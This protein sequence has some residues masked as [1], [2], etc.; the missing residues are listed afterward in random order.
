MPPS[1]RLLAK[2]ISRPSG[3]QSGS[4]ST[5]WKVTWPFGFSEP[6]PNREQARKKH[7]ER[8]S[9]VG[10][11]TGRED[12]PHQREPLLAGRTGHGPFE[13]ISSANLIDNG[14]ASKSWVTPL[15]R[16]RP[17]QGERS[18]SAR[19][20]PAHDPRSAGSSRAQNPL[21]ARLAVVSAKCLRLRPRVKGPRESRGW[22]A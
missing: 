17:G 1:V 8:D 12:T 19:P 11:H 5:V 3:D 10:P 18:S 9:Q 21:L 16:L 20:P 6:Q 22:R 2:A 4:V 15:T 7:Q 13:S 14:V